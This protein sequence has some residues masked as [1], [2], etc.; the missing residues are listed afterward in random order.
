M[1]LAMAWQA[2]RYGPETAAL[3]AAA[4]VNEQA[5]RLVMDEDYIE[6]QREASLMQ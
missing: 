6:T 2:F 1:S 4:E 5:E 3:L